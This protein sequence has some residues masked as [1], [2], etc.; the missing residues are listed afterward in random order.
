MS[1]CRFWVNDRFVWFWQ[2]LLVRLFA[3]FY[4]IKISLL[5]AEI[6]KQ[7]NLSVVFWVPVIIIFL[8]HGKVISI[9]I[10][11][12]P[13]ISSSSPCF[14]LWC[15]W[16]ICTSAFKWKLPKFSVGLIKICLIETIDLLKVS[17]KCTVYV[18]PLEKYSC[19]VSKIKV[20]LNLF[21]AS[22]F[23]SWKFTFKKAFVSSSSFRKHHNKTK[24][25]A[26]IIT[27]KFDHVTT[28][29]QMLVYTC[30]VKSLN[31]VIKKFLS[32]V[33]ISLCIWRIEVQS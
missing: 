28:H 8:L 3:D 21:F 29:L 31:D 5:V 33:F 1:A 16:I 4:L 14:G 10:W 22:L 11:V 9:S 19:F 30:M 6:F 7:S 15:F 23:W 26:K 2:K 25:I 24:G 17:N 18:G 12:R 32:Q 13:K 20:N 27:K